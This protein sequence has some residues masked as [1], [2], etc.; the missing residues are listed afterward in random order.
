MAS[1][2]MM[3]LMGILAKRSEMGVSVKDLQKKLN[4]DRFVTIYVMLKTLERAGMVEREVKRE[5][6]IYGRP[7]A[8]FRLTQKGLRYATTYNLTPLA[9]NP[10]FIEIEKF[11]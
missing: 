10:P 2:R 1:Y 3:L 9:D 11:K 6:R 7:P 8:N 5:N 4:T